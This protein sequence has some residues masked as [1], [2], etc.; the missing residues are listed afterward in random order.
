MNT[1]S[2]TVLKITAFAEGST[3]ML[4]YVCNIVQSGCGRAGFS[5]PVNCGIFNKPKR[6]RMLRAS[7]LTFPLVEK[8]QC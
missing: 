6:E 7:Y 3:Q 8:C 4:Y 2:F 1:I 5:N